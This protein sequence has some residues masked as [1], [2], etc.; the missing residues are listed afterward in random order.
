MFSST[1]GFRQMLSHVESR[2]GTTWESATEWLRGSSSQS[3]L[4]PGGQEQDPHLV[5]RINLVEGRRRQ[6][7]PAYTC[8]PVRPSGQETKNLESS[9]VDSGGS[10][11]E[12]EAEGG[13]RHCGQHGGMRALWAGTACQALVT[14]VCNWA[15]GGRRKGL[16]QPASQCRA[17]KVRKEIVGLGG[18]A[19]S[20]GWDSRRD[21][22]WAFT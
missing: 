8:L 4:S 17:R 1:G 6:S 13:S 9:R 5:L 19:D 12:R 15:N 21:L 18:T 22:R 20:M 3:C 16:G 11:G 7:N 2:E 10:R 14:T